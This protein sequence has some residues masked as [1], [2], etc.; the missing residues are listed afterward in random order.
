MSTLKQLA[1][2]L[3]EAEEEQPKKEEGE[4]SVDAQIDKYL[5]QYESQA[6]EDAS[7]K[8]E[9]VSFDRLTRDWKRLVEAEDEEN[10]E[11]LEKA[12]LEELDM[13]SFVSDVMRLVDNA[14]SLLELRNTILRRAANYLSENYEGDALQTFNEELLESHGI[15]I[16]QSESEKQDEFQPPRAGAAGPM[17]GGGTA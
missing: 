7:A 2:L 3:R 16:G 10:D 12:K 14:E 1:R 4:D 6:K 17:G 8:M 13:K 15:E 5:S 11:E 9:S